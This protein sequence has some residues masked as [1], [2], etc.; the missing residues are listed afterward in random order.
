M[1][2]GTELGFARVWWRVETEGGG[3]RGGLE[4]R[5]STYCGVCFDSRGP[6]FSCCAVSLRVVGRDGGVLR[7]VRGAAGV[8][9]LW[10]LRASGGL[11]HVY[12]PHAVCAGGQEVLYLQAGLSQ[13]VCDQGEF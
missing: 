13:C 6:F 5:L 1:S 3:G 8:G 10:S 11:F 2:R 9:G 4:P 12:C 7:S